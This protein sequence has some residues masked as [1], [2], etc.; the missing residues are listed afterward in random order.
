M[1]RPLTQNDL[2]FP[3]Q[4]L[5]LSTTLH[6]LKRSALS[7]HNRLTSIT[8]DS[9]F[10]TRVSAA[11][12]LP[13]VANERC[14]SWYIPPHLKAGSVYFKSTDG[15]TGEWRFS[16]RRLNLHL[17][18]LVCREGGCVVADSTRRGKAVPDALSKT[19]PVWCCVINRVVFGGEAGRLRTAPQAVSGSEHA[20]IEMR[21]EGFVR[22]FLEICK[23]DVVALREK[24]KKP[25]RPIWVTQ[26][27]SL[28]E[29]VPE[30]P[31][32]Y[33]LVLCTASRRVHGGEVS[34][35][36]YVQG[37]A[38]DHEAWAAGL[39]PSIFWSHKDD[40]LA[41]SEEELPT[42]IEELAAS[43]KGT[44]AVPLLVKP[45]ANLYVSSTTNLDIDPFD[46]II[47]CTP[48]PLTTTNID[49]V[50]G[51]RYLHLV[52]TTGKLGSRDL[53]AQLHNLP[54]FFEALPR[55]PEKILVC[56]PTGKDLS[57]AVALAILC[58]YTD[59]QGHIST[60]KAPHKLDKPFIKQRLTWLTTTHP[61]LNPPRGTLQ[62][63][64]AFLMPSSSPK[65]TPQSTTPPPS[66]LILV[67][68]TGTPIVQ[69]PSSPKNTPKPP[70]P[71]PQSIFQTLLSRSPWPFSRT[72]TSTLPTHPSGRVTG[73]ATFSPLDLPHSSPPSSTSQNALL[74]AEEG[75]FETTT[76][77]R[78]SARRKYIYVLDP[79]SGTGESEAGDGISRDGPGK[80]GDDP[81]VKV[82]FHD[83]TLPHGLGGLFVEMGDVG[84]ATDAGRS[85]YTAR[86]RERHLCAEDL[87][88]ASWRFGAGMVEETDEKE[89]GD[90]WWEVR[91]EVSGPKK[92]YVSVTRYG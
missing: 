54:A 63:V 50:R 66:R 85:V 76:G 91:Y 7:I 41:A 80:E 88:A 45:T 18:D 77:M 34:E 75:D 64:N 14:G 49:H 10:I 81:F 86:N 35:G 19:V 39:T 90:V 8:H 56:C 12:S 28:P 3:S 22:E 67:D 61:T 1:S 78:F 11:Y 72:L 82:H 9:T 26:E 30:Y 62:S 13:L 57:V 21:I 59:P 71:A 68:S 23:P 84:P 48:D 89:L 20:Q 6:S 32:F 24:L 17:L 46:T 40:L 29:T 36:G 79:G 87:Y 42:L 15:H 31:D 55:D 27:S 73:T 33:P 43:E 16:T 4:S 2:I 25:L 52:C 74:Y 38:D 69:P 47:S 44:D 65:D 60:Q 83:P 92:D 5:S 51:K 70:L 53:R 58:L 37:A